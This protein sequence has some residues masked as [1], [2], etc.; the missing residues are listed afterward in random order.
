M[1]PAVQLSLGTT[2]FYVK[3]VVKIELND[4]STLDHTLDTGS[5]HVQ[6]DRENEANPCYQRG[7]EKRSGRFGNERDGG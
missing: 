7:F 2:I 5:D 3:D 4:L 1:P 6:D